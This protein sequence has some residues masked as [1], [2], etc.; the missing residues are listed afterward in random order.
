MTGQ[1]F[2]PNTPKWGESQAT[3][4]TKDWIH[5][6]IT[7]RDGTHRHHHRLQDYGITTRGIG[8]AVVSTPEIEPPN[9]WNVRHGRWTLPYEQVLDG[10]ICE[11]FTEGDGKRLQAMAKWHEEDG[12]IRQL[13]PIQLQWFESVKVLGCKMLHNPA[14]KE[15]E[16]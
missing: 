1:T 3:I 9:E 16:V 11:A 7:T 13:I 10:Q 14:Q 4:A 5:Y 15:K 6:R 8:L 2:S 12:V